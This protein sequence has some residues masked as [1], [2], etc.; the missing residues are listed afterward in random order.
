MKKL[1]IFIT[2][3]FVTNFAF[4]QNKKEQIIQLSKSMDSLKTILESERVAYKTK[5][6]E[7][8][9]LIQQLKTLKEE[10]KNRS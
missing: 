7:Q 4:S 1:F 8:N 2:L 5:S 10:K 3:G 9:T 6:N